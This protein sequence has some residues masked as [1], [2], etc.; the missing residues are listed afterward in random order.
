MSGKQ[1]LYFLLGAIEDARIL[2]PSGQPLK[3]HATHDLKKKYRGVE[4]DQLFTKLEKDEKVIKIIKVGNRIKEVGSKYGL[5][6]PDDGCWHIELLPSFDDYF[7]KNQEE[8]EYQ[9]FTGKT[10]NKRKAQST[11]DLSVLHQKI[12]NKC[13]SLFEKEEY[14]EAVEKG[15]KVVRDKL[16]VLTGHETGSGAFGNTKLHIKGAAAQNVDHDF[17]EGVRFLT[18]AVDKFRN[19]KSHT[20][21]AKIDNPQRAY[22]YLT[23]SSLAMNLLDQAEI[24]T[25]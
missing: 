6:E 23:L 16:R 21:D 5:N 9:E 22:E 19:E 15:F 13:H 17:N 25:T 24:A 2:A 14:P 3:I 1:K 7:V 10:P 11:P 18:M 4:L 20:S 12:Y 8:P